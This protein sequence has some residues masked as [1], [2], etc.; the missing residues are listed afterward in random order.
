[1]GNNEIVWKR[2]GKFMKAILAKKVFNGYEFI[3]ENIVLFENG[4]IIEITNSLPNKNIIID[5]SNYILTPGFV[6]KHTHGI[7]GIEFFDVNEENIEKVEKHYLSHGITMV[8]PTLI[9]SPFEKIITAANNLLKINGKISI[10]IPGIFLEGPF[11]NPQ[12]R[13]A[14][15][16]EYIRPP[17][18]ELLKK[19]L[20]L[21]IKMLDIAIAPELDGAFELIKKAIENGI[22]VSLG[23]TDASFDKAMQAH[24]IGAKNVVHI[25]NAM[26]AL[27]HRKGNITLYSLMSD[28][29]V[30]LIGDFIHVNPEMIML[31]YKLKG[32]DNIILVSDSTAACDMPNGEYK[33][34][35]LELIV[36]DDTCMLKDGTIA[37]SIVTIDKAIKNLS[38]IGI[39]TSS[40]LRMATHNPSKLLNLK[41]GRIYKGYPADFVLLDDDLSV[42]EVWAEGSCVYM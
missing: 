31:L 10:K 2:S 15:R 38:Q 20:D 29:M 25:F 37:G 13:G 27:H 19:Y 39:N 23:H 3:K 28:I 14:H 35:D 8:V 7:G 1:M 24:N 33:L 4:K 6:D 16:L 9:S 30:E 11:I 12:K 18:L 40:V 22:N 41:S 5:K 17:S 21:Q 36:E 32:D 42:K 34:G 26:P